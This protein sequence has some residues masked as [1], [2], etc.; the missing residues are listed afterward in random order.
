MRT[1]EAGQKREGKA[2]RETFT[3][4]RCP[5]CAYDNVHVH[6]HKVAPHWRDYPSRPCEGAGMDAPEERS[7]PISPKRSRF[8]EV[9]TIPDGYN[10][11]TCTG[12][13]VWDFITSQLLFVHPCGFYPVNQQQL[14]WMRSKCV[15]HV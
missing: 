10:G 8:I 7:K 2:M 9:L 15:A 5:I 3:Y 11:H 12:A 6:A 13:V 4:T 1:D 14:D